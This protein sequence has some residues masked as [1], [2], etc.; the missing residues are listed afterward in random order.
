MKYK[1]L[2]TT[3]TALLM[4]FMSIGSAT[5]NIMSFDISMVVDND[6]AVFSGN[7][8]SINNLMY[9][10]NEVWMD[11]I[12]NLSTLDFTLAAGDDRF[13]VLAMGGGGPEENISGLVN[14][15][16]ITSLSVSMSSDLVQFLSG[17]NLGGVAAGTYNAS[18]ADVQTAFSAATWGSPTLDSSQTVIVRSGFGSGFNFGTGTAHLFSFDAAD[19]GV[20]VTDVP[21]PSTLA[22]FA[23]G[24]IG[25]T[26]RRFKK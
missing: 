21:E 6:F 18:L 22:I 26:T 11:Q 12:D 19:V 5:A 3:L 7:S 17:Y 9:Q 16:N 8:T 23:L 24:I 25:L 2:K 13:Y 1:S 4:G 10:N 15:V 20:D 14:G